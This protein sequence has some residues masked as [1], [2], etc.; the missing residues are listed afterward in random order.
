MNIVS[1]HSDMAEAIRREALRIGFHACGFASAEHVEDNVCHGFK[2]WLES[3]YH[4]RMGYMGNYYDIRC[5]PSLLHK[6]V[7]TIISVALNYFPS[8][9]QALNVPQFAV[10]TYGRDYHE[11]V[12]SKLNDLSRY[13]E[14]EWSGDNRICCDTAPILERYWAM[15]AGIGFIGKNTQLIIPGAGSFFFLGE[16]LTSLVLKPSPPLSG[17]CGYCTRCMD[18]CPAKALVKPGVLDANR[19]ISYQTIENRGEI[20]DEITK[21]LG[22]RIYGCDTCQD[23]CPHNR[24]AKPTEVDEFR[25]CKDFL[26]LD[27]GR[28]DTLTQE[29]YNR[30]F[31]HSA[32]KRAKYQGLL[33]NYK[34][35]KKHNK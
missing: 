23:V 12:K 3:G 14:A 15:K 11:V 22:N 28:L 34:A 30:I 24:F 9:R 5:D 35:W 33:R 21:C 17:G 13:I 4:S 2:A 18:S 25:P 8:E 7:R 32:V 27:A 26:Q 6:P 19:C 16:I 31:R 20:P 1:I 10:Y 29:E